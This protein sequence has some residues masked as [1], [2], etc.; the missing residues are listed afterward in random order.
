[1]AL[2]QPD[3]ELLSLMD[4]V[5]AIS[6]ISP[7]QQQSK[8]EQPEQQSKPEQPEQPKK[9]KPLPIPLVTRINQPTECKCDFCPSRNLATHICKN[10]GDSEPIYFCDK[11]YIECK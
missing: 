6:G 5:E 7:T 11:C 1:M 10:T 2:S 8:P 9:I 4:Q 3:L